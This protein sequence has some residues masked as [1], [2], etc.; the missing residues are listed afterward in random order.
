MRRL[1]MAALSLSIS[2]AASSAQSLA[3]TDG[4]VEL[5]VTAIERLAERRFFAGLG[6]HTEDE[7]QVERPGKGREFAQLTFSVRWLPGHTAAPCSVDGPPPLLHAS[8]Y[9]L[10]DAAG[11]RVRGLEA[12]YTNPTQPCTEFTV[13]FRPSRAGATY[14]TLY[15]QGRQAALG[16][17]AGAKMPTSPR[18]K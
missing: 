15:F 13:L 4:H 7:V 9:L 2:A 16:Q 17:V 14:T 6:A 18:Q 1:S 8:E 11:L 12:S 5:T 10:I 3:T